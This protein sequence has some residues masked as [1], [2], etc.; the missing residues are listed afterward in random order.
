MASGTLPRT[1]YITNISIPAGADLNDYVI[2]GL[3][4]WGSDIPT[5]APRA[6]CWMTV[7]GRNDL[8][9]ATTQ[10][11]RC[12]SGNWEGLWWERHKLYAGGWS[13]WA[14]FSQIRQAT[15]SS[16]TDANSNVQISGAAQK[17][18]IA[19]LDQVNGNNVLGIPF[20]FTNG[21]T[22]LKV[23]GTTGSTFTQYPN[24]TVS[25]TYWYMD[26]SELI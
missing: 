7:F 20:V 23:I 22:F 10:I 1:E 8:G 12:V 13:N 24:A 19:K 17:V 6:S 26:W 14:Q 16:T 5:N 9:N 2:P 25:G 4:T 11:A 15:F 18:L 3:Y 21:K